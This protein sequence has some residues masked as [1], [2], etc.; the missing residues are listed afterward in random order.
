MSTNGTFLFM[1]NVP[2]MDMQKPSELIRLQKDMVITVINYE[3]HVEEV[4]E[5]PCSDAHFFQ[6]EE[7]TKDVQDEPK[8]EALADPDFEL[9]DENNKIEHTS[10]DGD[11]KQ[12]S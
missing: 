1:K 12:P 3:I 10:Y 6:F 4:Q 8:D 7:K 2:E 9:G 5:Q 11:K